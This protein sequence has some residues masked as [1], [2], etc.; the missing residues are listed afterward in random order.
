MDLKVI[1][2]NGLYL[3]GITLIVFIIYEIIMQIYKDFVFKRKVN[4]SLMNALIEGK[5]KVVDDAEFKRF[6]KEVLDN[7]EKENNL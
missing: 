6:K 2:I 1:L 7:G 3:L 5:F 4:K